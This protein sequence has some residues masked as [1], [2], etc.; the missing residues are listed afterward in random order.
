MDLV[1]G[2]QRVVVLME[3]TAKGAH[4]ILPACDLPL[5][6]VGVVDLIITDL[7]V[8][9]V[10]EGGLRLVELAEGVSL[11]ELRAATGAPHPGLRRSQP[12][13]TSSSSLPPAPRSAVSR[14]PW[15]M[16]PP[17]SSAPTV[18]RALLEQTGVAPAQVDEVILGQVLT[19]APAR[20]RRARQRSRRCPPEVPA[21]T[22][23]QGLRLRPQGGA[24][25]GPGDPLRRRRDRHRRRHGEHEPGA[26]C[27]AQGT[28]RPAA[29]P[30]RAGR[31]H[32]QRWAVGCLQRLPHGP[33]RG[34]PGAEVP[35][36]PRGPGR[37]CRAFPAARPRQ[38]WN[39]AASARRSPRWPFP[40]ARAS[41]C[42]ST[43]TRASASIPPPRD[44]RACV[45][46]SPRTA[47]SPPA[48]PP[49]S[50]TAP[51]RCW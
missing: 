1:A 17:W 49:A 2:V 34:E 16:C 7:A 25:G 13:K 8:L 9:E 4:K 35:A 30:C 48:T 12:C 15:P 28:H 10:T 45:R 33:D 14:A 6:G 27:A 21:L 3:H 31:L 40:S 50:T 46:P 36:Q 18:I 42:C 23:N 19:A 47:A 37:L 26:L 29:G 24:A 39:P 51:P 20:I 32:A 5:T 11:D 43:P 44:W 38:R 41:R 22:L